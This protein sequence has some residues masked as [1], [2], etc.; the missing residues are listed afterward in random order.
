MDDGQLRI[1]YSPDGIHLFQRSTGL[2]VLM[3]ECSVPRRQWSQGP[4]QVSIA[5]TNACD[6]SCH[7]CYAPKS[8]GRLET[9]RVQSWL[10]EL[11]GLGCLGVGFGGGEPTLHPDFV[12][13]CKFAATE[14]GLA[15]TF[16]T[17]GHHL[18]PALANKLEGN[19]HFI[20]I[21]MDGVYETYE[22]IRGRSFKV[23]LERLKVARILSRFGLNFVVNDDTFTDLSAAAEIAERF[24]A[25]ELLLLPEQQTHQSKG[26]TTKTLEALRKWVEVYECPVPLT[27]SEGSA[28]DFPVCNPL[29]KESPLDAFVH[30]NAFGELLPTSYSEKGVVLG[31]S[32][33]TAYEALRSEK[34]RWS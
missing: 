22:T 32:F 9:V 29:P 24:G 11:D 26:I 31:D 34:K 27:I 23:F 2:N 33:H 17:H 12:Q 18:T 19:V 6:L 15:V 16:T 5:L 30:I 3:D 10:K 1:R 28:V 4:R 21:S 8:K 13:L 25:S 7:F 14:T 20:R